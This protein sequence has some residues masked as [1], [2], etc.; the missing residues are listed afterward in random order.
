[1]LAHVH[2]DEIVLEWEC[3]DWDDDGRPNFV[4]YSGTLDLRDVH[5]VM[6]AR[7][8]EFTKTEKLRFRF[9]RA[10]APFHDQLFR[11]ER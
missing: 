9:I 4:A 11:F 1:M 6:V 3:P 5:T 2:G 8:L 10:L 7:K